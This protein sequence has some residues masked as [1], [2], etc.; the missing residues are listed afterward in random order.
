MGLGG[1]G[2]GEGHAV[3]MLVPMDWTFPTRR[4]AGV[5]I[6]HR[7]ELL[8]SLTEVMDSSPVSHS[9]G[10]VEVR[11]FTERSSAFRLVRPL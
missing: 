4:S 5:K 9:A 7:R 6:P 1:G 10:M 3:P 8:L 2:G 11:R